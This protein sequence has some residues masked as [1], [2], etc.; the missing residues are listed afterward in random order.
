MV[1]GIIILSV[2]LIVAVVYSIYTVWRL[3]HQRAQYALQLQSM[4]N[5]IDSRA[6]SST[7]QRATI[8]GQLAEQFFPLM[9]QNTHEPSDMRFL[10]DF[11][12]FIVVDGYGRCKDEGHDYIDGVTFIEIKTGKAQLSKHQKLIR[13]AIKAGRV[14]WET[15]HIQ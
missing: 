15:I 4:Q 8:K 9:P 11:C 6:K 13:D 3:D 14:H 12:D 10:G 7:A 1:T 2:L 5:I